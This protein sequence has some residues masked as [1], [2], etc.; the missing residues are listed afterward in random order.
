[1]LILLLPIL[2]TSEKIWLLHLVKLQTYHTNFFERKLD[3][4]FQYKNIHVKQTNGFIK[5]SNSK[6]SSGYDGISNILL[7]KNTVCNM[8]STYI[9]YKSILK[10]WNNYILTNLNVPELHLYIKR[11]IVIW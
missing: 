11:M 5:Q 7:K 6:I 3:N 1:M 4:L 10:Y 2:E 8:N 9:N